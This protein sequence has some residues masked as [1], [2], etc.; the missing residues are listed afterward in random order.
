MLVLCLNSRFVSRVAAATGTFVATASYAAAPEI[1]GRCRV[2]ETAG[3]PTATARE[4]TA[5]AGSPDRVRVSTGIPGEV[6]R[7]T[8]S[9]ADRPGT[10]ARKGAV[11]R[12]A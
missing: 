8:P 2:A 12:R 10:E 11:S 4:A 9:A 5:G 3:R 1:P 6:D 7:R